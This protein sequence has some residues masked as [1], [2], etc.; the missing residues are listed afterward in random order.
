M[1]AN[2]PTEP[3][4]KS[5]LGENQWTVRTLQ[6]EEQQ[7]EDTVQE[8]PFAWCLLRSLQVT[9]RDSLPQLVSLFP[10]L[11][12]DQEAEELDYEVPVRWVI[13]SNQPST[14]TLRGNTFWSGELSAGAVA[15]RWEPLVVELT[16]T[17][18][19][20]S[21]CRCPSPSRSTTGLPLAAWVTA[22][23]LTQCSS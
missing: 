7:Q 22:P 11:L 4:A 14:W 5:Y 20:F 15:V 12:S 6:R 17:L 3:P 9:L 10:P 19:L 13:S 18:G 1:E 23:T 16:S 8:D 21:P 2:Y